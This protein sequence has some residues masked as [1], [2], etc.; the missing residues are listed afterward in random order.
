[1]NSQTQVNDTAWAACVAFRGSMT[2]R[3]TRDYA[4]VLFF[5][6]YVS[7]CWHDLLEHYSAVAEDGHRL[8]QRMLRAR[9]YLPQINVSDGIGKTVID[10]FLADIYGLNIRRE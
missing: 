2:V 1:M 10:S 9:F 7:D 8:D 5:L 4:L 3:Q 6:K